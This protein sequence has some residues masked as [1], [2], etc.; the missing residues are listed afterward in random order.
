MKKLAMV[1]SLVAMVALT[2]SAFAQEKGQIQ[3]GLGGTL[4]TS[5]KSRMSGAKSAMVIYPMVEGRYFVADKIGIDGGLGIQK[6]N[7]YSIFGKDIGIDF[8]VGGRYYYWGQDKMHLNAGLDLGLGFG[9]ARE[10]SDDKGKKVSM[11]MDIRLAL[12]EF[13]YWPMEGGA[14]SATA[15]FD[16]N[17]LNKGKAGTTGFGIDLGIKIRIK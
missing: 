8:M 11:P 9:K 7:K 15:F 12:T 14:I 16:Y 2:T 1:L 6:G 10:T 17:G 3:F 5:E 4:L 13:E